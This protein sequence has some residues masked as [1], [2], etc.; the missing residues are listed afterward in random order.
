MPESRIKKTTKNIFFSFVFQFV[1][2]ALVFA[3]RIIF[4]KILGATYLG[5]NGL[6]SNILSILSLA[7]LGLNTALMYSLYKPLATDDKKLIS[8]YVNYFG[9]VY[10]YIALAV[11]FLGIFLTPFLK[12]LV[13]LPEE[14]SYIYLYYYLLLI[15]SVISYL[16]VY[17][18]TI[19]SADQ[20][21]Y[22][23]NKYDTCFQVILFILHVI[24]LII[25]KS[26][27]LY[28]TC[29]IICTLISNLLKVHKT[30]KLYPYIIELKNEE[31]DKEERRKIFENVSSSFFYNI[32]G[33]I[34]SNT[35]NILISVFVGTITVGYFSNYST[36]ITSIT[37]FVSL[38]FTS[39]KASLGSFVVSKDKVK[40]LDMFNN[41]EVYNYWL[42]AAIIKL[43]FRL[44]EIH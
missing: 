22:I 43:E 13:N 41:L 5:I 9:K 33:V 31:L 10:N 32:G 40:Q 21:M 4:V 37:S 11:L 12:Y 7:D 6:F 20:K 16:F 15:N 27:A 39:L 35:D 44:V 30:K 26:F 28:L 38:I 36:I 23:I 19:L 1:T 14:V 42:I 2:I 24:V 17:K 8:K 3:N 18:T 25:T 34:Q 29:N